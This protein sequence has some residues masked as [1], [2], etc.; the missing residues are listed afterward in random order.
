MSGKLGKIF[1]R[2]HKISTHNAEKKII[3]VSE[4][5]KKKLLI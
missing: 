2:K 3:F 5:L 1:R 4:K